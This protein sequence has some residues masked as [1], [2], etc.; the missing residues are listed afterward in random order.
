MQILYPSC[1]GLDVHK[2]TVV[3]CRMQR[4]Q[5][6]PL[7]REVKTFGT[8]TRDLLALSSTLHPTKFTP[9]N[10]SFTSVLAGTPLQLLGG[11]PS[12]L[13]G[14]KAHSGQRLNRNMSI[15]ESQRRGNP[16]AEIR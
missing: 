7:G 5:G 14:S 2:K 12:S 15:R 11:V 16:K 10:S 6:Q 3:A 8:M 4:V 9:V 13:S 1:A